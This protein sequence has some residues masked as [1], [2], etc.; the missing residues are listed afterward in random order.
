MG[1]TKAIKLLALDVDGVL[2]DG[3]LYLDTDGA[4]E[5]KSFHVRDGM[6]LL[7]AREAGIKTMFL[8]GRE[9]G[10]IR[11]RG[12]ELRVDYMILG[13]KDKEGDIAEILKK[14]GMGLHNVC[15]IGD[16]VQDLSLLRKVGFSAAPNN[17]APVV[18]KHVDYISEKNGGEGAV[19]D[20][21]DY[22]LE[23]HK[24][25]KDITERLFA[26]ED[27][28]DLFGKKIA[29]V[30]FWELLRA[31]TQR[32]ILGEAEVFNRKEAL[33]KRQLSSWIKV[34]FHV[35]WSMLF[36]NPFFASR[37]NVL[38][39]GMY[40]RRLEKDGFWHDIYCDP[41]IEQLEKEGLRCCMIERPPFG[42]PIP[43]PVKTKH[44]YYFDF[45]EACFL[46]ARR[47]GFWRVRLTEDERFFLTTLQDKLNEE[48]G[49]QLDLERDLVAE[50]E[51]QRILLPFYKALLSKIAPKAVVIVNLP[52]HRALVQACKEV[53]VPLIELQQGATHKYSLEHSYE[54]EKRKKHVIP[55]YF[56]TFGDY[57]K[58]AVSFPL[59]PDRMPSVGFPYY[60]QELERYKNAERKKQILFLSQP[61]F[62]KHMSQFALE[63]ARELEG[64][65]HIVYKLHPEEEG[66]TWQ[67][68]YS[69]LARAGIEVL[70]DKEKPLYQMLAESEVQVAVN[71][72]AT[73]EGLG[74][75]LRTYILDIPGVEAM[76]HLLETGYARLVGSV[77][78]MRDL[79]AKQEEKKAWSGEEFFRKN[80]LNRM[81][82][83]I[84]NI[85]SL[86]R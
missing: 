6:G 82:G 66:P 18:R 62:G 70:R 19:R 37:A 69:T 15:F 50:L 76:E 59:P 10:A 86:R 55:D 35:I 56:F 71:S 79:L 4:R 17:A 5:I 74:F 46:A 23:T 33:G 47:L 32:K 16:D 48:F 45:I 68:L 77:G 85:A 58:R 73:Y 9:S 34:G 14:E 28:M 13:S 60:E 75:G 21:V 3:K 84:H 61:M 67:E 44:V 52:G 49:T 39:F 11:K 40:R 81:V 25:L 72:T 20:I 12:G 83:L 36:H 38:F 65:W 57:W 51:K 1:K 53:R 63:L 42:R 30:F 8:S 27:E 24:G 2:T 31:G 64:T 78:E 54:G 29:G 80:S 22:I 7:L 26:I 43:R 41:L